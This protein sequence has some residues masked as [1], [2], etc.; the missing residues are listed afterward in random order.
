MVR[1]GLGNIIILNI[2]TWVAVVYISYIGLKNIF[3]YNSLVE[4]QATLQR[5]LANQNTEFAFLN[6]QLARASSPA[7]WQDLAKS[8]MGYASQNE[9]VFVI[10]DDINRSTAVNK[11]K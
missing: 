4:R 3:R 2:I 9:Q 11:E 10:I 8:R 7:H 5:E 6:H 1:H